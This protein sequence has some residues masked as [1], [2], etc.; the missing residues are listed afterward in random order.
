MIKKGIKEDDFIGEYVER[1]YPREDKRNKL[2]EIKKQRKKLWIL[3]L[4]FTILA[5]F[6]C[7]FSK[8]ESSFLQGKN[9]ITRQEE[10]TVLAME[11][12]A[13]GEGK[14]WHKDMIIEVNQRKFS[15]EEKEKL[16]RQTENYLAKNFPGDNPSLLAVS[17]PLIMKQSIP[18]TNVELEWTYDEDYIKEDGT[19]I[20][21]AIPGEGAD[22]EVSVKAMCRNWKKTF[23]YALHLMPVEVTKEQ[24]IGKQVKSAVKDALKSQDAEAVVTLP[25]QIGDMQIQYK[26][27]EEKSYS[28]VLVMLLICGCMP[29]V[30][31]EKQK[32]K[33]VAREEQMM[34]DHPGIVNKIML[35][36]GAGLTFRKCVERL[37][38]EYERERKQGGEVRY[39]YEELCI[40][41][42]EMRDG[43]SEGQAMERFGKR[44]HLLPYIRFSTVITQNLKKGAE[45]ILDILEQESME[46]LEQRKERVLQMGEKAGTKL[47]FPMMIMLG[48]V[49]GIIMIPAFMTM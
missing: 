21:A 7:F 18:D 26:E 4:V 1:I 3:L 41:N 12:T 14:E 28:L 49:M 24:Q 44:C 8:P 40:M 16:E 13:S 45:G 19:L 35:L 2:Q 39:A 47:L 25:E 36:L 10:D 23:T 9:Q 31:R 5:A 29:F 38:A 43:I 32:K 42:Q 22:T 17:K 27:K 48:L 37:T 46:A 33:L 20:A 6:Y 34:A 11:V 30:L 15:E